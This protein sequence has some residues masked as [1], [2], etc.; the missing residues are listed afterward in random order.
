MK[1]V[2][3]SLAICLASA[4]SFAQDIDFERDVFPILEENCLGCH[5]EDEQESNLRLD[6]RSIMLRGGD[7][8]LPTLVPGKPDASHMLQLIKHAEDGMEMPPEQDKLPDKSIAIIEKWI[9][10]GAKWPGPV[11]YTHLTLPTKA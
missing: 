4:T 9:Q 5:G 11:S 6:R 1:S 3:T 7:S 10:Q 8:G 2:A